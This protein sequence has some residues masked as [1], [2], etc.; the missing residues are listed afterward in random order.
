VREEIL[1]V[2][3]LPLRVARAGDGPPLLLING[4]GA[5]LEMWR[6]FARRIRDREVIAFDLPGTGKSGRSRPEFRSLWASDG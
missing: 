6:P 4:L 1:R 3:S 2:D 5:S